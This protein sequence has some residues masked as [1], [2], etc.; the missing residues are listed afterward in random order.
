[1]N[2]CPICLYDPGP[3]VRAHNADDWM[4]T[5][6]LGLHPE[7]ITEGIRGVAGRL[8]RCPCG[9]EA[10]FMNMGFHL[11]DADDMHL[12]TALIAQA[13]GVRL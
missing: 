6:L 12:T 5:H 2:R 11:H 8:Y 13:A 7:V 9:Y 10:I 4:L 3:Q 1:M